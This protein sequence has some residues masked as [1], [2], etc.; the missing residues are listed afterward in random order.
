MPEI[1][2]TTSIHSELLGYYIWYPFL[3]FR[4]NRNHEAMEAIKSCVRESLH[5]E[6]EEIISL[7]NASRSR[8]S[9][10]SSLVTENNSAGINTQNKNVPFE[11]LKLCCNN[12]DTLIG[13]GKSL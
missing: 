8:H 9:T 6:I 3:L 1:R 4:E 13:K 12:F 10:T 5:H 2:Y 11:E 7:N